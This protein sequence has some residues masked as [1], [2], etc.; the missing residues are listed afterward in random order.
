M[1]ASH[2]Q[3]KGRRFK[4]NPLLT[5]ARAGIKRLPEGAQRLAVSALDPVHE[6]LVCS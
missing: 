1:T 5:L 6:D 3:P 4:S 2:S